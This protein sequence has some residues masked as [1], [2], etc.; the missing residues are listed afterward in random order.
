MHQQKAVLEA[1][2]DGD[3]ETAE[4]T[5]TAHIDTFERAIRDVI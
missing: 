3:G 4:R 5:A 1:I 2:C